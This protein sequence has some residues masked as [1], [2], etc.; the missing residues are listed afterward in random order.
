MTCQ[1]GSKLPEK[2]GNIN[3][4]AFILYCWAHPHKMYYNTRTKKYQMKILL[5]Q[6]QRETW[7][8]TTKWY[9][10]SKIKQHCIVCV[11]SYSTT[12]IHKI[13]QIKSKITVTWGYRKLTYKALRS[14][15]FN[16]LLQHIHYTCGPLYK[17]TK[18][19]RCS[20]MK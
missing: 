1:V 20:I 9:G 3:F 10:Y 13:K 15:Y 12:Q 11:L 7:R 2:G 5:L 18:S 14:L 16:I 4:I 8:N 17:N 19:T 6:W